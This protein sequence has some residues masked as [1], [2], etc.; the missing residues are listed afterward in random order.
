MASITN[1]GFITSQHRVSLFQQLHYHMKDDPTDLMEMKLL[2]VLGIEL[3]A[4]IL[5]LYKPS[6]TSTLPSYI[7]TYQV[8]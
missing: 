3:E 8:C 4:G 2:L 7:S 6:T 5:S 1:K